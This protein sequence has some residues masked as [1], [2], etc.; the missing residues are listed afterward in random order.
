MPFRPVISQ[1]TKI[2]AFYSEEEILSGKLLLKNFRICPST[3]IP[4]KGSNDDDNAYD[5]ALLINLS[6]SSFISLFWEKDMIDYM[7]LAY[8]HCQKVCRKF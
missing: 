8:T 4:F 3:L 6:Y 1:R 7:P 2:K 5:V